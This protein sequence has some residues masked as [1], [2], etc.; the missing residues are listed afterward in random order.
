MPPIDGATRIRGKAHRIFG[1]ITMAL[2]DEMRWTDS[3]PKITDA[4]IDEFE[5]RTGEAIPESY[6]WF[7]KSVSNGGRPDTRINIP[8]IQGP[9]GEHATEVCILRGINHP[10]KAFDLEHALHECSHLGTRR[11]LPIGDDLGGDAFLLIREGP[12]EGH[13]R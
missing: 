4:E 10:S 1:I 6:R 3:G 12:H 9:V 11:G 7:L 8:I 5:R 2:V 13:V